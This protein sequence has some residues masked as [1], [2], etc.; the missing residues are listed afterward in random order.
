MQKRKNLVRNWGRRRVSILA[1]KLDA[2]GNIKNLQKIEERKEENTIHLIQMA[3][4]TVIWI[5]LRLILIL[6]LMHLQMLAH[7]VMT[8]ERRE[9]GLL[10]ETNTN[11]GS[12]EIGG[13]IKSAEGM[14]SAQDA[15]QEGDI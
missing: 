4:L 14:T 11:V 10:S 9:R 6:K 7:L 13:V 8:G 5:V 15:S 12:V 2:R 3:P 1:M